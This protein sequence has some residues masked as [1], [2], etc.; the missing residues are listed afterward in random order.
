MRTTKVV[1]LI[2]ALL[3]PAIAQAGNSD[4][5]NAGLDVTLTG[6]AV[7]ATTYTGAALWYNPAGIARIDKGSLEITGVTL[8]IQVIKNPGLVTVDSAPQGQSE[9]AGVNF[10]VIPQA[11]TFTLDPKKENL[12]IGVGMFNSS[13]RR[14][15]ITEQA[16]SPPGSTPLVDAYAGRN[17]R[18]DF[19]HISAG[20]AGRFAQ[21]RKQKVLFGGTFDLVVASSRVDDTYTVFYD[22]G[23]SGQI[24]SGQVG[25]QTGFGF[26]PK[27]GIQ[28]VPIPQLR[29]GLSVA[30]PTY[31]FAVLERFSNSFNQA[32]PE[33]TIPT[34]PTA[35]QAATGGE[36]RGGRGVWWAVEPGNLRF[37]MA[38][39]GEWGWIEADLIYYFRLEEPEIG[40][41]L[42]GFLNG[43]IGSAFRVTRN[44]K[45]GLGLFTDFSQVDDL[46][47]LPLATRKIDFFGVHLGFLYSTKEV[48]PDRKTAADKDGLDISIA[49]G[50]RYAHGRGDTLG[51]LV[52]AQYDPGALEFRPVATKI[53]EIA[54]NLG[55][56][57]GF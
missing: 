11:I 7:V 32:P 47:R 9:G 26:Q 20:F 56:K 31:V 24:S 25:T 37:G 48:H 35:Q 22:A 36:G 16:Q 39:V 2:G 55:A 57:V 27:A 53:N 12:K 44:V 38:Y 28:Y 19:F 46:Q 34:D 15:F 21:H 45:L 29:I 14:E 4:E 5:V 41:D 54:I 1:A 49:V 43:R 51:L 17:S 10:S 30:A 23:K 33:G 42:R 18:L 50:L 52:P 6:G 3:V 13:I 8:N 40:L